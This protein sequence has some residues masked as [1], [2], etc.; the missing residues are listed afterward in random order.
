MNS[1]SKFLRPAPAY[2]EYAADLLA[3]QRYRLMT[4][5]ERGLWDTLRKECWVNKKVP[6]SLPV[7]AKFLGQEQHVIRQALTENVLSF[8]QD[9]D[10]FLICPELI[11]YREVIE[12]RRKR[13]SIGGG[14]GGKKTQSNIRKD[15]ANLQP[16]LKPL[17]GE[18]VNGGE[19]RGEELTNKGVIDGHKDWLNGYGDGKPVIGMSYL[20]QS[21]GI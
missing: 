21:R 10:G 8:F 7:L 18:E 17:S 14:I 2:Q 4:L 13:Q 15:K 20:E 16:K 5:A 6:S 19:K 3:D 11:A 9:V 1:V 12:D